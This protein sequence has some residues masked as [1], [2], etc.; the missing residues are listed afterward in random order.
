MLH[1]VHQGQLQEHWENHR[2]QVSWIEQHQGPLRRHTLLVYI[3]NLVHWEFNEITH[4]LAYRDNPHS[5]WSAR[6]LKQRR[7]LV[8]NNSEGQVLLFLDD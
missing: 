4:V 7:G 5:Q 1:P 2:V 8:S 3:L 6:Q